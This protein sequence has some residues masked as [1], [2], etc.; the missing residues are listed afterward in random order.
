MKKTTQTNQKWFRHPFS[1]GYQRFL[2]IHG[3]PHEIAAGFALG[4]FIAMSPFM[5]I[6]IAMAVFLAAL[7]RW[8]KISAAIAVW[9]SNPVT[10]PAIYGMTWI[11][12]SKVTAVTLTE[13]FP[14][15]FS[16]AATFILLKNTPAI[17]ATLVIGGIILGIP[18]AIVAYYLTFSIFE[19]YQ[20]EVKEKLRNRKIRRKKKKKKRKKKKKKRLKK[21][22]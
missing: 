14:H 1:R 3:N 12:G 17:I 2:K 21:R 16:L 13:S 10:A 20:E 4:L 8:N 18:F 6:H 15:T 11:V 5:G 19:K 9:V 22:C 7:L